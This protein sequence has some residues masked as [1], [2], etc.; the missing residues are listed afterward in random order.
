MKAQNHSYWIPEATACLT[1]GNVLMNELKFAGPIYLKLMSCKITDF[2]LMS[3]A[4][5]A[6]A[7][8]NVICVNCTSIHKGPRSNDAV[9]VK[10]KINWACPETDSYLQCLFSF[11][12]HSRAGR[13][14]ILFLWLLTPPWWS[15]PIVQ[16]GRIICKF[17]RESEQKDLGVVQNRVQS[18]KEEQGNK[19]KEKADSGVSS[20][21][22]QQNECDQNKPTENYTWQSI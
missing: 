22:K 12:P 18:W 10:Y 8:R 15:S 20:Q 16:L 6:R 9:H 2:S 17:K 11:L 19:H 4:S 1:K 3:G 5:Y 14:H 7:N 21:Q 13:A